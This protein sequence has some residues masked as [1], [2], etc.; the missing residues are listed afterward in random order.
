MKQTMSKFV[1]FCAL[2]FAGKVQAQWSSPVAIEIK[3]LSPAAIFFWRTTSGFSLRQK[4]RHGSH[5]WRETSL[6]FA[7]VFRNQGQRATA[8]DAVLSG[9]LQPG[10]GSAYG[11]VVFV[12]PN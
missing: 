8:V 12:G 7:W 3:T 2:V 10:N 1:A 4:H 6:L 11:D 9:S 5:F